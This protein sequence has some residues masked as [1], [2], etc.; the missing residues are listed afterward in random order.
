MSWEVS[1]RRLFY[2]GFISGKMF[3]GDVL[4]QYL[5]RPQG[6][7]RLCSTTV[8]DLNG[9]FTPNKLNSKSELN[10]TS[11]HWHSSTT[12][13]RS[14]FLFT[15]SPPHLCTLREDSPSSLRSF[16]A[17]PAAGHFLFL[18]LLSP[19]N[20]QVGVSPP[21]TG[22]S[23]NCQNVERGDFYVCRISS[24]VHK[25]WDTQKIKP[26]LRQITEIYLPSERVILSLSPQKSGK[27]G[28]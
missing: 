9:K 14:A 18:F 8:S 15:S 24:H 3:L 4:L 27:P 2:R 16:T 26:I 7:A 6:A 23:W 5:E 11:S 25:H 12:T 21:D 13:S 28:L 20:S 1:F 10:K 22:T 19:Q 17:S